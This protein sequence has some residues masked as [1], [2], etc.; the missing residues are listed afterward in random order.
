MAVRSRRRF[1]AFTVMYTALMLWMSLS[2]KQYEGD[3]A[4]DYLLYAILTTV[5]L[6]VLYAWIIVNYRRKEIATLKCIG[7]NNK[8]INTLILGEIIF[9]TITA[10]LIV[11]E[12][13]IHWTAV[14]TY[15]YSQNANFD[16]TTYVENTEPF[17][18]V[19][20]VVY[21]LLI[22]VGSQFIGILIMYRKIWKLRPIVALRVLK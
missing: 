7:Y 18:Q 22:F 6:S 3:G 1:I 11:A 5:V 4:A 12:I 8:N 21:T 20:N 14:L 19:F 10:F 13:L 16:A 17:L 9:V 2:F 15:F